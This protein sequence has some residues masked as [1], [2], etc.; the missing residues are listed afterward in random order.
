[1]KH[2][3]VPGRRNR[4]GGALAAGIPK[5]KPSY[6]KKKHLKVPHRRKFMK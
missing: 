4:W 6:G 1:M 5:M 3:K 2:W